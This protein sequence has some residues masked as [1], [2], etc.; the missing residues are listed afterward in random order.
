MKK[1]K[2]KWVDNLEHC[3]KSLHYYF[4]SKETGLTIAYACTKDSLSF[5]EEESCANFYSFDDLDDLFSNW[6]ISLEPVPMPEVE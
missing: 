1:I 5:S 2:A 3:E 4:T 6:R